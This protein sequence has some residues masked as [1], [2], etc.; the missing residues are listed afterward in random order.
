MT[1]RQ[2]DWQWDP[3]QLLLQYYCCTTVLLQFT[4]SYKPSMS[5]PFL[6]FLVPLVG[7]KTSKGAANGT[8][9]VTSKCAGTLCF[10]H[11][12]PRL[13]DQ[14]G[15]VSHTGDMAPLADSLWC[16]KSFPIIQHY[17]FIEKKVQ[18]TKDNLRSTNMF[19]LL[20][21]HIHSA[22]LLKL[23]GYI[24]R[25]CFH[26]K[27]HVYGK[28]FKNQRQVYD[29]IKFQVLSNLILKCLYCHKASKVIN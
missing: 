16:N 1:G 28:G 9:R 20:Y 11:V 25:S 21:Q 3:K 27:L 29:C 24:L 8:S 10:G 14:Q 5:C 4:I 19:C 12:W 26:Q 13:Q 7:Y 18:S 6:H 15:A 2:E 17:V 22:F 23:L